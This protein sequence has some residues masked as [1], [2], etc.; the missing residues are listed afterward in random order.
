F[1]VGLLY[2]DV[3]TGSTHHGIRQRE[4]APTG[5]LGGADSH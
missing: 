2:T 3:I 5:Q 4:H 1:R